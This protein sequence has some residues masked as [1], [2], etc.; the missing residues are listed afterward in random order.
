MRPPT[1]AEQRL[2]DIINNALIDAGTFV[3][4]TTIV[5]A[6]VRAITRDTLKSYCTTA[7]W[8][9][10]DKENIRRAHFSRALNTLAGKSIIGLSTEYVW[11]PK[12]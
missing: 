9:S 6:N 11:K 1:A 7:G 12:P 3:I 2:I 4:D 5:P 8:W 10:S